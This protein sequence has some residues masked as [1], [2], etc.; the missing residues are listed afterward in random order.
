MRC[1]GPS[2]PRWRRAARTAIADHIPVP[3]STGEIPVRTGG[4]PSSPVTLM[5]PPKACMSGS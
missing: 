2:G 5:I 3:M 1:P 4:R